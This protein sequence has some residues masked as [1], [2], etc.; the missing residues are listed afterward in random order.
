[1]GCCGNHQHKTEEQKA[2]G[3]CGGH[4]HHHPE[5]HDQPKANAGMKW[6][7]R[8]LPQKKSCCGGGAHKH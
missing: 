4:G 3:C 1:M 5:N 8:L 2:Q 6:W 7:Q